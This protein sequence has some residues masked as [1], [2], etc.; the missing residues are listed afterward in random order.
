[1][2][3]NKNVYNLYNGIF[4]RTNIGISMLEL[5]LKQVF[6]VCG[7][8]KEL[9]SKITRYYFNEGFRF[10]NITNDFLNYITLLKRI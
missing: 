2:I 7:V 3:C 8:H 1:M 4:Q 9:H 10:K 6:I 5:S